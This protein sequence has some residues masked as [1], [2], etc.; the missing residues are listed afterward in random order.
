MTL[1]PQA[2]QCVLPH[3]KNCLAPEEHDK[4]FKCHR[5]KCGW[6]TRDVL[7]HRRVLLPCLLCLNVWEGLMAQSTSTRIHA[8]FSAGTL[9]RSHDQSHSRHLSVVLMLWWIGILPTWNEINRTAPQTFSSLYILA[10]EKKNNHSFPLMTALLFVSTEFYL[11]CWHIY[12][13]GWCIALII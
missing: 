8:G 1:V 13:D 9:C 11:I 10:Q 3:Y 12:R 4:D 2:G 6:V 7:I 5:F